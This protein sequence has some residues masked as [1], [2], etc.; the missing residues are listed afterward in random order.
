MVLVKTF[1]V[2]VYFT[3]LCEEVLV[4]KFGVGY[5]VCSLVFPLF[6]NRSP[7]PS[8]I[9]RKIILEDPPHLGSQCVDLKI[10]DYRNSPLSSAC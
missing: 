7:F 4:T 9:H 2:V 5:P 10:F 6:F 3:L 1:S 8:T